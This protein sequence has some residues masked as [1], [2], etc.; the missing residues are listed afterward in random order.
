MT[1][2]LHNVVL[3]KGM[4]SKLRV[5]IKILH[6]YAAIESSNQKRNMLQ[7]IKNTDT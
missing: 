3:N 5:G 6:N 7:S 4:S 1:P 2:A